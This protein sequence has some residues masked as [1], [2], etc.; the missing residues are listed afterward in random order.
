MR[1]ALSA[2]ALLALMV[3]TMGRA[4]DADADAEKAI[5]RLSRRAAEAYL[6]ADTRTL[7]T[8]LADDFQVI[9]PFGEVA[10]KAQQLKVLKDGTL[11]F[12]ELETFDQE[13]R[14][15]GDAAVLT[16]RRRAQATDRSRAASFSVRT[17]EVYARRGGKWQ[18][19]S[20][21]VTRIAETSPEKR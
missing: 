20:M 17:T 19:V 3:P 7:D 21:Q 16:D 14:V 18:C 8:V 4:D 5:A 13:V 10:N 6:K 9:N 1:R 12:D 11:H 15:Y 2:A